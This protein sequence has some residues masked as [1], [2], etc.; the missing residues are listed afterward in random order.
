MI[1]K[2]CDK[3]GHVGDPKE[4][5]DIKTMF[6]TNQ[7]PTEKTADFFHSCTA[8]ITKSYNAFLVDAFKVTAEK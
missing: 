6:S 3:C 4:F 5:N 2:K 1:L 7:K 8:E